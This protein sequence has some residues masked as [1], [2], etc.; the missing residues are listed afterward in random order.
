MTG[1]DLQPKKKKKFL[2]FDIFSPISGYFGISSYSS[3]RISWNARFSLPLLNTAVTFFQ[4]INALF[5]DI[6]NTFP[7][8]PGMLPMNINN[9]CSKTKQPILVLYNFC[10]K[11]KLLILVLCTFYLFDEHNPLFYVHFTLS[12][13]LFSFQ[14]L[15]ADHQL[16]G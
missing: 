4:A 13:F 6:M 5:P 14:L 12:T 8:Y 11:T 2:F 9:K 3:P 15:Y 7:W 16:K 10:S 1:E